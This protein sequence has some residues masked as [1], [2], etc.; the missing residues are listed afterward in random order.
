[1]IERHYMKVV[2]FVTSKEKKALLLFKL[3]SFRSRLL[4]GNKDTSGKKCQSQTVELFRVSICCSY[5]VV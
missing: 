5:C 1:M 3:L 4:S 2:V